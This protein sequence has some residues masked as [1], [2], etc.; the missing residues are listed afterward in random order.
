MRQSPQWLRPAVPTKDHSMEGEGYGWEWANGLP[1]TQGPKIA[2]SQ[3][4]SLCHDRS[5]A[6]E[7]YTAA[8]LSGATE[9]VG[10]ENHN[11]C[12]GNARVSLNSLFV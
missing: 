1:L 5:T 9:N 11:P 8:N 2:I 6:E 4:P 7:S 12:V 3:G 10:V